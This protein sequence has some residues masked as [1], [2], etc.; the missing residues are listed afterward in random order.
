MRYRI[1]A[2]TRKL[3][4]RGFIAARLLLAGLCRCCNQRPG[5][6]ADVIIHHFAGVNS[7]FSGVVAQAVFLSCGWTKQIFVRLTALNYRS[8][9]DASEVVQRLPAGSAPIVR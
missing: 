7:C 3:T 4:A 5:R 6:F 2:L 9:N 1:Y 8:R